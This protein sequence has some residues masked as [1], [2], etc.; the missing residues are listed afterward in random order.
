MREFSSTG[1][2]TP[3]LQEEAQH[4]VV[5]SSFYHSFRAHAEPTLSIESLPFINETGDQW[6]GYIPDSWHNLGPLAP[7]QT[8]TQLSTSHDAGFTIHNNSFTV[9]NNHPAVQNPQLLPASDEYS[10][11]WNCYWNIRETVKYFLLFHR[12]C[13]SS[14]YYTIHD[15]YDMNCSP[16]FYW[17]WQTLQYNMPL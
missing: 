2:L 7:E 3:V 17:R 4:S 12:N 8:S 9:P 11:P 6:V 1:K 14:E 10:L 15:H 5:E 16:K 13:I